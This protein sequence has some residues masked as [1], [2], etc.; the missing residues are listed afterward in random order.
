MTLHSGFGACITEAAQPE[1]QDGEQA[2]EHWAQED[3][4]GAPVRGPGTGAGSWILDR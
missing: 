1:E 2:G 3:T 4:N